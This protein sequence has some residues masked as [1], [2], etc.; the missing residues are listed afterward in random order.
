M[1]D[2]YNNN[3][4]SRGN[5][6]NRSS[7][8]SQDSGRSERSNQQN[9]QSG[10]EARNSPPRKDADLVWTLELPIPDGGVVRVQAND[11]ISLLAA[12]P[13]LIA[14][15]KALQCTVCQST[16]VKLSERDMDGGRW[17][18]HQMRCQSPNCGAWLALPG[19][20]KECPDMAIISYKDEFKDWVAA[21]KGDSDNK[22]N[23]RGNSR[24]SGSSGR[25]SGGRASRDNSSRSSGRGRQQ[26][27]DDYDE[28]SNDEE[29]PF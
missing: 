27:Q 4:N 23:S 8:R 5:D 19:H 20:S 16:D 1:T 14:I 12:Y 7:G 17:I 21:K 9:N 13:G 22:D 11:N 18:S 28:P 24:S 29:V 26:E 15:G 25:G 2:R 6:N 10:G 3:R